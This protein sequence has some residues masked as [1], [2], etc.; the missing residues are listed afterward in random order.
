MTE[1]WYK[2][3]HRWCQANLTEN[4]GRDCDVNFWREFW[5]KNHIEGAIINAGGTVAYFPSENPYQYRAKHLGNRDLL[6]EFIDAARED[7]VAVM[8]RMDVNQASAALFEAEPSWFIRD[9]RGD[10]LKVGPR[11]RTCINGPYYREHIPRIM[12][13]IIEKYRPDAL[14]DNSWLSTGSFI[15][16]CENCKKKFREYSGMDL[17]LEADF[18]DKAYRLWVKWSINSRT[19]IWD[20]YKKI[21]REIGGENCLWMGMLHP[22][23]YPE[24]HRAFYDV[25]RLSGYGKAHMVDFQSRRERGG[26]EE[27][28]IIG[29]MLHELFGPDA[30]IIESVASYGTGRYIARKSAAAPVEMRTWMLSG[31]AAGIVPSPHFIG[32]IQDDKRI[33]DN[34]TPVMAWHKANEKYLFNRE[35]VANT[36]VGW[37]R[38]NAFFHGKTDVKNVCGLPFN[39]FAHAL[40]RNRIPWFP[41]NS[42]NFLRETGRFDLLILPD[43]A[44]M[45]D[46]ELDAVEQL[47]KQGKSLIFSGASGTKDKLGYIR[48]DFPLDRLFGLERLNRQLLDVFVPGPKYTGYELHNYMR[49]TQKPHEIVDGLRTDIFPFLGQYYEVRSSKL[50]TVVTLVPPFPAFPPEFCY[51]DDDKKNSNLP[52]ILAGETGYGGRVVYLAGDLDRRYADSGI[53][54]IGDILSRAVLWALRGNVPFRVS[55]PGRLD[56]KLYRQDDTFIIHIVNLSGL[57]EWPFKAE[58][59]FPVNEVDVSVNTGDRKISRATLRVLGKDMKFKTAAGWTTISIGNITDHEMIILSA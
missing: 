58:Q 50:E 5:R 40:I 51:M 26:F 16:Y 47:V 48:K 35:L 27:N 32:G 30:L 12:K 49:V 44:V 18:E 52:L 22:I 34:C 8:A 13:E 41:V 20:Y 54:D 24:G 15:C 38:E 37:N 39:G 11:Y 23:F 25:S 9:V 10:P 36:A 17:P 4:D 55:G 28:G 3:T 59:Y 57:N 19:G 31:I 14:G 42:K 43:L 7:G 6:K 53:P 21:T 29:L 2:H 33:F 1:P 45:G 56:C 46:E